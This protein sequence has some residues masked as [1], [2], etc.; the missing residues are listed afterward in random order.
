MQIELRHK[1]AIHPLDQ[2]EFTAWCDSSTAA[3]SDDWVARITELQSRAEMAGNQTSISASL[4]PT[5]LQLLDKTNTPYEFQFSYPP[6]SPEPENAAAATGTG[7]MHKAFIDA[8]SQN[9]RGQ[10]RTASAK[11]KVQLLA[12]WLNNFSSQRVMIC[13]RNKAHARKL[14]GALR[15]HVEN[16]KRIHAHCEQNFIQPG[17]VSVLH[18][19]AFDQQARHPDWLGTLFVWELSLAVQNRV[20]ETVCQRTDL[21]KYVFRFENDQL[22]AKEENRLN[23]VCGCILFDQGAQRIPIQEVRIQGPVVPEYR[24]DQN[25]QDD[26]V[27]GK[28]NVHWLRSNYWHNP[29]WNRF[30]AKTA[31]AYTDR[32]WKCLEQLGITVDES[33]K[34]QLRPDSSICIVVVDGLEPARELQTLLGG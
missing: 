17:V 9:W 30:V 14:V 7:R 5:L 34:K 15:K 13:V 31:K 1:R 10:I 33:L 11:T 4:L 3:S 6:R 32:D 20:W 25:E 2:A 18:T 8:M 23:A 19:A 12:T 16:P 29:E 27:L 28:Q 24:V 21:C 26:A 22:D